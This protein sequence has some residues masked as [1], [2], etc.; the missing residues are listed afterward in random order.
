MV[1]Y[2]TCQKIRINKNAVNKDLYY[3][4][5]YITLWS[6][7]Q[8]YKN[9]YFNRRVLGLECLDGMDRHQVPC[10]ITVEPAASHKT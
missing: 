8:C 9:K 5:K 4:C 6:Q 3:Q 2:V 1:L 7:L 10:R